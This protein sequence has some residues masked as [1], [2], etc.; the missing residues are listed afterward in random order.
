[1]VLYLQQKIHIKP[2]LGN[3]GLLL[4]LIAGMLGFTALV[5]LSTLEWFAVLPF[6]ALALVVWSIGYLLYRV[7]FV[8]HEKLHLWDAMVIA[9]LGWLSCS[10]A[11]ALPFYWLGKLALPSTEMH[12]LSQFANALFESFSGFT[13][14]GLSILQDP[15]LL[16]LTLQWWRSLTQWIGGIGLIV[17]MLSLT[18]LRLEGYELYYAEARSDAIGKNISATAQFIILTYTIL[19]F[20]GFTL[21]WALG[22]PMWNALNHAMTV[23]STGGFSL[24]SSNIKEYPL[25]LQ[26]A[27]M[28]LMVL[29]SISFVVYHQMFREKKWKALCKNLEHRFFIAILMIGAVCTALV[30]IWN[31][32]TITLDESIFQWV[33]A[34]TTCGFSTVALDTFPSM[35]K[36]LLIAAMF[37]GGTTG[38]TVGGL[39]CLRILYLLSGIHLRL[40]TIT[41]HKE[42]TI[43]KGYRA[44]TKSQAAEVDLPKTERSNRLYAAGVLFFLWIITLFLGWFFLLKHTPAQ[45]PLSVLFDVASALNNVGLSSGIITTLPPHGKYIVITIMW[46]GRLEIVPALILFLSFF[47]I[48]ARQ[49]KAI[50]HSKK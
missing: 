17:F 21:F 36:V 20:I 7:Y 4:H 12:L 40:T 6:T 46:L 25:H 24:H 44:K 27:S 29:G 34:L 32:Y 39:K 8:H 45:N 42:K 48:K 11:G 41:K 13:S 22:M 30:N 37:I 14:T 31:Q 9:A 23:I 2:I 16:P 35:T 10:F 38:S 18:S 5:A 1:M 33:S 15:E 50:L 19:T 28:I 49:K 26:I 47:Q 3:L 43:L